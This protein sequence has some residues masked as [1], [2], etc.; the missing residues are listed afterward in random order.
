M[1]ACEKQMK[2]ALITF[3]VALL[4]AIGFTLLS[5]LSRA[6]LFLTL[7]T[8][9]A[10]SLSITTLLDVFFSLIGIGVFFVVFYFI[11]TRNKVLAG[12][13]TVIALLLGVTVG[14]AILYLSN[15]FL[16]QSQFGLYLSMAAGSV[17]S[18][19]LG[20]FF[21]ALAALLFV[22]LRAKKTNSNLSAQ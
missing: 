22:E 12:K 21:P 13:S 15:I 5:L 3:F 4:L 20:F 11:A 18:S 7:Q 16:Y 10:A 17:V 2:K 19:V 1:L 8:S 14:P 6:S 9:A